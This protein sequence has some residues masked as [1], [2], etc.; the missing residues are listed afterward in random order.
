M[1]NMLMAANQDGGMACWGFLVVI[2]ILGIAASIYAKRAK[3]AY[4]ASLAKLKSDPHNPDLREATLA[5][6]R[7][8]ANLV[9]KRKGAGRFDEIALTNDINAACARAGSQVRIERDPAASQVT[10]ETE[11][12]IERQVMVMRCRFCGNLTPADLNKCQSCGGKQ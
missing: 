8:Y 11:R 10:R 2:I 12:V 1:Q 7:K 5:L 4:L 9:R 6:G 3:D